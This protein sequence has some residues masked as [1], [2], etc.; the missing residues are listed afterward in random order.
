MEPTPVLKDPR[1]FTIVEMIVVLAIIVLVTAVALTGQSSFN[2]SLTITDTAYTVALSIRQA[3]TYGLS[4]RTVAGTSVTNAGYGVHFQAS[5]NSYSMFADISK[6]L[7][8]APAYCPTGT[9]GTPEAKPGNCL[10]DANNNEIVQNYTFGRGFTISDICGHDA[11]SPT[12]TR[13]TST[14]YLTGADI[15]FIRP[16]TDSIITGLRS[17]GGNIQLLDAQIKLQAPTGGGM[18]YVCVTSVG[19]VSVA[20]TSCP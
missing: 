1:G 11:Q 4:S 5:S 20:A 17:S 6:A 19:E 3:Q 15:V 18:R 13:C 8:S 12:I 2:R 9:A 16:N 10:Y 7:V 14:G